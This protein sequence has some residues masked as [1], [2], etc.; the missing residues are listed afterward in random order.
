[1][2]RSAWVAA[3]AVV[4]VVGSVTGVVVARGDGPSCGRIGDRTDALPDG[5]PPGSVVSTAAGADDPAARAAEVASLAGA[6]GLGDLAWTAPV[7]ALRLTAVDGGYAVI[8]RDLD[9]VGVY[10]DDGTARWSRTFDLHGV[11]ELALDAAGDA[12]VLTYQDGDEDDEVI[13]VAVLAAS[14]GERQACTEL[15]GHQVIQSVDAVAAAAEAGVV[16]Y[17][18]RAVVHAVPLADGGPRWD[19]PA[20][21]RSAL[22]AVGAGV[23]LTWVWAPDTADVDAV[24]A[25]D[26]VTGESRWAADPVPTDW[27]VDS[28]GVSVLA[29]VV[30]DVVVV[31]DPEQR[32]LVVAYVAATGEER[33]RSEGKWSDVIDGRLELPVVDDLVVMTTEGAPCPTITSSCTV[34]VVAASGDIVWAA[35]EHTDLVLPLGDGQVLVDRYDWTVVDRTTGAVTSTDLMAGQLLVGWAAN[36]VTAAL[37]FESGSPL[38]VYALATSS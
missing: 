31:S 5:T 8:D 7:D 23:A 19:A 22:V 4:V 16:V 2:R 25:Y 21:D 32:A 26:A 14:D 12:V 30:D 1:V 28:R 9:V 24:V 6:P 33:W 38:A 13:H 15:D 17:E 3:G 10:A 27:Y 29:A 34:G 35:D 20:P 11:D 36:G 18:E 37:A